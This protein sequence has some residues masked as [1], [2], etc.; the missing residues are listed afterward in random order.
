MAMQDSVSTKVAHQLTGHREHRQAEAQ[1][2]VTA[3]LQQDGRQNDRAGRGRLHV[4]VGQPGV[5]G[6]HRHLHGEAGEEGQ[7]QQ[8]LEPADDLEAQPTVS[9]SAAKSW[10]SIST[11]SVEPTSTYIA[12][13]ATSIS[14]E[15][16]S[17]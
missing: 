12:I 9:V 1:E 5:H 6:P 3:H 16:S 7:P 17:V 4:G 15:P 14:S 10:P 13:I 11:M 2:P 8:R